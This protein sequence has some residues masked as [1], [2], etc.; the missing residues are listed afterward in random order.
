MLQVDIVN[1]TISIEKAWQEPSAY[2]Y[3]QMGIGDIL[4]ILFAQHLGCQYFASFDSDFSRAKDIIEKETGINVVTSPEE[5]LA[6]L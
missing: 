6:I 1:F 2:A 4:H 5:I 3:L